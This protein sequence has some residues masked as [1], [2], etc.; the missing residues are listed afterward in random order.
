MEKTLEIPKITNTTLQY[1]VDGKYIDNV[2]VNEVNKIRENVLEYIVNTKNISILNR[3]YFIGHKD[4]ND[5]KMGEEVKI[6]MDN[7]GNLSYL[8]WEMAHVRRSMYHLMQIGR[9]HC[10]LLNSFVSK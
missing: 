4:T 3:F 6:T 9:K 10:E 1:F 5:G 2:D 7:F 8:P